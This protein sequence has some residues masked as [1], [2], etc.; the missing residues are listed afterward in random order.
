[1]TAFTSV[2]FMKDFSPMPSWCVFTL[3]C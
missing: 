2:G 1:V 3:L